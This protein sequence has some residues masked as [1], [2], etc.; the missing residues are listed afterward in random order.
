[1]IEIFTKKKSKI[2]PKKL[3][4]KIWERNNSEERKIQNNSGNSKIS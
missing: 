3:K 4:R 2:P 1:L